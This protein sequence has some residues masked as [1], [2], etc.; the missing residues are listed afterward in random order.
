MHPPPRSPPTPA[1]RKSRAKRSRLSHTIFAWEFAYLGVRAAAKA[2]TWRVLAA[3]LAIGGQ[4]LPLAGRRR[5]R[6]SSAAS[7]QRGEPVWDDWRGISYDGN[8]EH[9]A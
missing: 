8:A 5:R 3:P 4:I 9:K 2:H 1:A 7:R 6:S